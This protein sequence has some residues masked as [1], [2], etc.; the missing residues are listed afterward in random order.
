MKQ[1]RRT[2]NRPEFSDCAHATSRS[3]LLGGVHDNRDGVAVILN[4]DGALLLINPHLDV[5]T[6]TKDREKSPEN[7]S[8]SK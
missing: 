4:T 1:E 3:Y 5:Y 8:R 6:D 7:K 2:S